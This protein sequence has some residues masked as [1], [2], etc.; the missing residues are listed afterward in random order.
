MPRTRSN[1]SR[2]LTALRS[3]AWNGNARLGTPLMKREITRNDI[4]S[5][6]VYGRERKERRT[7]LVALKKHRR[8]EV[9]PVCTFHFENYETM[10]H[11]VHEMLFIEKGGEAQVPDE[12]AAYNPLIPNGR[13]LVATI[14]FEID[15]PQRR[16]TF[17]AKL[18]GV[19]ET[20]SLQF[21]GET[22]TGRAEEDVERTS[23]AGKASAVQF[24]HF[25]FTAD[26]AAKFK[27][28][29]TQVIVGF[30]HPGYGH[31]AVM[32]EAIRAALAEDLN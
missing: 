21:D 4:I 13:E 24:I 31:M 26:Q 29:G 23:A 9:G 5:M 16:E 1:S 10:W 3:E 20:A 11:Q 8:M 22:V 7:K 14:M 6:E 25:P 19:E 27:M 15:E 30:R 2:A 32:P 18:G 28:P 17:L 12:L